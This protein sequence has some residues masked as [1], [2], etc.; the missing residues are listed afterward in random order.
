MLLIWSKKDLWCDLGSEQREA[1]SGGWD[2]TRCYCCC[3]FVRLLLMMLNVTTHVC[4]QP[5]IVFWILLVDYARK[6]NYA[7]SKWPFFP[8]HVSD[9]LTV[10]WWYIW[11]WR[12][13]R[14]ETS[15][16]WEEG[17]R[18]KMKKR[19]HLRAGDDSRGCMTLWKISVASQIWG[20]TNVYGIL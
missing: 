3:R 20:H 2:W 12:G 16:D 9:G 6:G 19:M 5:N 1:N 10:R 8:R 17:G 11:K 4:L 18:N 15:A 14:K 13:L 7:S